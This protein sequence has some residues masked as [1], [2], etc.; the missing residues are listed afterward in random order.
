MCQFSKSASELY[1]SSIEDPL[2]ASALTSE[3]RKWNEG[4]AESK[5]ES[6][7]TAKQKNRTRPEE[8]KVEKRRERGGEA[9][10]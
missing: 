5:R 7:S 6:A 10:A 1:V 2:R 9:K 3:Q 8:R 4:K